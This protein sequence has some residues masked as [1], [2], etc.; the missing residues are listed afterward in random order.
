M[1]AMNSGMLV[2]L[3]AIALDCVSGFSVTPLRMAQ[4][5]GVSPEVQTGAK[6][7]SER[8]IACNRFAVRDGCEA[9]FE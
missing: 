2:L 4:S 7:P 3:G 8:Y 9:E 5:T 1:L 6:I